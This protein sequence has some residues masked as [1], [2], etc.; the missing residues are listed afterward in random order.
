M[1]SRA[2]RIFRDEAERFHPPHGL[3]GV[4]PII[5][6][7][8]RLRRQGNKTCVLVEAQDP[9]NMDCKAVKEARKREAGM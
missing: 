1:N 8:T 4:F 2:G 9:G 3:E 5:K 6:R 7:R